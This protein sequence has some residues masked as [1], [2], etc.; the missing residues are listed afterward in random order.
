MN[1]NSPAT[2][3]SFIWNDV[4]MKESEYQAKVSS[5]INENIFKL[6]TNT[7]YFNSTEMA[8]PSQCTVTNCR[9]YFQ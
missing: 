3:L 4:P 5:I 8:G 6:I 7:S 2:P 9:Q 1:R